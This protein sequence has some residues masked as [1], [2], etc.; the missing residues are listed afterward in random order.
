MFE[1]TQTYRPVEEY[2]QNF[3][4]CKIF[5]YSLQKQRHHR[6]YKGKPGY[7]AFDKDLNSEI[8]YII[9]NQSLASS[10]AEKYLT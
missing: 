4:A 9:W 7:I 10:A 1:A 6:Q 2:Q 5:D 8:D 3:Q